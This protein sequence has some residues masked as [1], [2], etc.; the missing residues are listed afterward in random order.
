[1]RLNDRDFTGSLFDIVIRRP[2]APRYS[3]SKGLKLNLSSFK[4]PKFKREIYPHF[5]KIRFWLYLHVILFAN[6]Y[7]LV[8]NCPKTVPYHEQSSYP[9]AP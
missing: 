1:M 4:G 6:T 5:S 7:P 3:M 8:Y 2:P 9:N